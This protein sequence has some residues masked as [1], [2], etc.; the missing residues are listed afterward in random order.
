M[1]YMWLRSNIRMTLNNPLWY[2]YSQCQA[3]DEWDVKGIK[4]EEVVEIRP[5]NVEIT[6]PTV[7]VTGLE[8]THGWWIIIII[9]VHGMGGVVFV[10]CPGIHP[11]IGQLLLWHHSL[12]HLKFGVS[13]S[14]YTL[15]WFIGC[16]L[17][18]WFCCFLCWFLG[19]CLTPSLFLW[20]DSSLFL[21][22]AAC[23]DIFLH[24]FRRWGAWPLFLTSSWGSSWRRCNRL[25]NGR[26]ANS[27]FLLFDLGV[28]G[29]PQSKNLGIYHQDV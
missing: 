17:T 27:S 4:V 25:T 9:I 15:C 19:F 16:C 11:C 14:P 20:G 2:I 7:L 18:L 5:H 13:I 26:D 23:G 29:I 3:M 12:A 21:W 1:T 8:F 28:M 24:R 22:G 10:E 6:R